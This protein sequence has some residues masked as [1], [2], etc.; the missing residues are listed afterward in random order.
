MVA[1]L[2]VS[3]REGAVLFVLVLVLMLPLAGL[4]VEEE[5]DGSARAVWL[6][7]PSDFFRR[8]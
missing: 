4:V 1:V 3:Q 6:D 7:M 2:A 5:E 8:R